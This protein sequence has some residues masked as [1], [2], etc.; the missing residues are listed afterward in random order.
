MLNWLGRSCQLS[1]YNQ[2]NIITTFQAFS[3][4]ESPHSNLHLSNSK[5]VFL[6]H[7]NDCHWNETLIIIYPTNLWIPIATSV[8]ICNFVIIICNS[9]PC[10]IAILVAVLS[11]LPWY[12]LKSFGLRQHS[13]IVVRN[14]MY[15][16]LRS[17]SPSLSNFL[18]PCTWN[19]CI[20]Y[21]HLKSFTATG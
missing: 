2:K 1:P 20:T 17:K 7:S 15:A 8:C 10:I 14:K 5:P 3:R 21:T 11:Y 18:A 16:S 19:Y 9:P 13:S 6:I 12:S 4:F